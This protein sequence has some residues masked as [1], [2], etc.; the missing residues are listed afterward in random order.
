MLNDVGELVEEEH[1]SIAGLFVQISP[2]G[3]AT[4]GSPQ[5]AEQSRSSRALQVDRSSSDRRRAGV[6]D[7]PQSTVVDADLERAHGLEQRTPRRCG[8]IAM[9]SPVAFI[10]VPSHAVARANL[11]NGQRGILATT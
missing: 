4:Q 6:G 1:G 11:S 9:T 5:Q 8:P 7:P 10:W 2:T 3:G